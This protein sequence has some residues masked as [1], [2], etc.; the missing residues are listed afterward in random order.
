MQNIHFQALGCRL[1]EA[2]LEKWQRLAPLHGYQVTGDASIA[3][4]IVVNTCAVTQEA[5]RKSR[6]LANRLLRK[7]QHA[8]SDLSVP[9]TEVGANKAARLTRAKLVV[10]GCLASID[11]QSIL[12]STGADMVLP[13]MEKDRLFERLAMSQDLIGEPTSLPTA[14]KKIIRG[15][16]A[17][18]KRE[19][20]AARTRAFIKVQDGCRNRCSF[21]IVTV[22]RGA[23]R[24]FAV[25]DVIDEI[26]QR[27]AEGTKEVVL[28]GVHLGGYGSDIGTD[29]KSLMQSVLT[30]TDVPRIRLSSLEPW[31]LPVDFFDLW[32]NPRLCPHLHLPIQSGSDRVLKRM[33]RRSLRA[34]F[35]SLIEK[36]RESIQNLCISTDIIV[37]FPGEEEGDFDQSL[38]LCDKARFH[39]AHIFSYSPREGTAASRMSGQI[40][41]AVKKD[42]SKRLHVHVASIAGTVLD[43]FIDTTQQVLWERQLGISPTNEMRWTGLTENY[44]RCVV[45]L[46]QDGHTDLGN[47]ITAVTMQH[48]SDAVFAVQKHQS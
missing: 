8:V 40:D 6:K 14:A 45:T 7:S 36:A 39:H 43:S 31:D 28:S 33:A 47:T 2:E 26:N 48:H 18:P 11:P 16:L 20:L 5:G 17:K 29:L 30:H 37:G 25:G 46:P 41:S 19:A 34:D 27:A 35:L 1:N 9:S 38:S 42:R 24:S 12:A 32:Q 15:E 21:C 3:D 23:E 44:L 13:N 10:T 4:I 22:A